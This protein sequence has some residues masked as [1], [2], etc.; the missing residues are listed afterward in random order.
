MI[1]TVAKAIARRLQPYAPEKSMAVLTYGL[2]LAIYTLVSTAGLILEGVLFGKPGACLTI[3]AVYYLNQTVGGGF[4][5]ASHFS[6]FLTMAVGLA[7]GLWIGSLRWNVMLI[8]AMGI[9]AIAVL[10]WCPVVLHPNKQYLL[11]KKQQCAKRSRAVVVLEGI[12]FCGALILYREGSVPFAIAL[13][14]SAISRIAGKYLNRAS[15]C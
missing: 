10:L 8:A 4:H 1:Q 15:N 14:F 13:F 3:I 9:L 12:V 5:A 7:C 6:C 11:K 2:D